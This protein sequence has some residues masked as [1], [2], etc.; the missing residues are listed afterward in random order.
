MRPVVLCT[1]P[2]HFL[3]DV[4][5]E[6]ERDFDMIYAFNEP[7][8]TVAALLP[9]A[10]G[11]LT[12]PGT[13][14]RYDAELL[15]RAGSLRFVVTP[16]TGRDHIDLDWCSARGVPVEALRGHED[17]IA[18]IHSS[19]EFSFALLMAMIRKLVPAA[20]GARDGRWREVEDRFRGIELHSKKVFLVGYG[21]I[22]RKMSRYLHAFD[23]EVGAV[24]PFQ[25][26][27]DPWVRRFGSLDEGLPWADVVCLHVHL[28]PETRG[29]FGA[30]QFA[31]MKTGAY[32]LNTARGG[33]VEER[34]L[35]DALESGRLAG[36]AVDVI[37]GEQGA[38][39]ADNPLVRLARARPD[40]LTVT[41]HIAGLSVDSQRKA[42]RFAARCLREHLLSKETPR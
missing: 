6:L 28:D 26:G 42:A 25:Q 41:P 2:L 35:V 34:A 29:M 16:S 9:R 1:A 27:L 17:V 23:A 10:H 14:F 12:N 32:F 15:S 22:G 33:L 7:R 31:R 19:A 20:E 36:A 3:P 24:D 5:A 11:L 38:V 39:I 13:P 30:P 37:E 4:K 8:E 18:G 21:R 40:L